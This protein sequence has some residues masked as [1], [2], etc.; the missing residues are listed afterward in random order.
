ME[1]NGRTLALLAGRSLC[2]RHQPHPPQDPQKLVHLIQECCSQHPDFLPPK[3]PLLESIFRLLLS[4]G[5]EP[6]APEDLAQELS[7]RRGQKVEEELVTGVLKREPRHYG[8]RAVP[9]SEVA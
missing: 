4:R 8:L 3:L 6:L 9:G 2:P 7:Q 5:N 1:Q